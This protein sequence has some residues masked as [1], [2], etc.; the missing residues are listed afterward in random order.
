MAAVQSLH[1][2]QEAAH[3]HSDHNPLFLRIA[4]EALADA[5]VPTSS[6]APETRVRYDGQKAE[7]YQVSLASELQQHFIPLM[8]SQLDVDLLCEKLETCLTSAA[9]NP[10]PQ[11]CKRHGVHSC[12]HQPWFDP[13][14]KEALVYK[15]AV[16]DDPLSTD[17]QENVATKI[18]RFC[19]DRVKEAWERKRDV[20]LR[21][22][23][24][25]DQS[26]FWKAFKTPRS[27]ACL[28]E[29]TVWLEAFRALMGA[30]P[31]PAPN[32]SATPGVASPG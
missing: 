22:L 1:V 18:Y 11:A 30:E 31:Q 3:Y 10:M 17:E 13:S 8:H 16:W 20:E 5:P 14:C 19:T 24:A 4:C 2:V 9:S 27:S 32:T 23:A 15:N 12:T 25:K 28:V 21:E 7:A 6:T 26:H 29:L